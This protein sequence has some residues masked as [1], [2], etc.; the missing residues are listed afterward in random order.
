VLLLVHGAPSGFDVERN[1]FRFD[2]ILILSA[3]CT[4]GLGRPI[5]RPGIC[6]DLAGHG[7]NE[8]SG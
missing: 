2:A 8:S 5:A 7:E 4:A 1:D 3:L 6:G